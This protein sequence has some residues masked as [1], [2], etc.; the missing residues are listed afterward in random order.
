MLPRIFH[1]KSTPIDALSEVMQKNKPE[2]LVSIMKE[3]FIGFLFVH[4]R[5]AYHGIAVDMVAG[6]SLGIQ[7]S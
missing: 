4:H 3:G 7:S 1:Q 5:L 6:Y 2:I